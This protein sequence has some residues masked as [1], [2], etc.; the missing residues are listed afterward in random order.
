MGQPRTVSTETVNVLVIE[1]YLLLAEMLPGN[2]PDCRGVPLI[3][4]VCGSRLKPGGS[5][6]AE[7]PAP[8]FV[9][10]NW[11]VNGWKG[12]AR[13][14]LVLVIQG[15]V[16]FSTMK[17]RLEVATPLTFVA[18][19]ETSYSPMVVGTPEMRPVSESMDVPG[20]KPSAPK[21]V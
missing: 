15:N 6:T 18:K 10:C 12:I 1:P 4:P 3:R 17:V 19:R 8:L 5:P 13:T 7:K 2:K 14:K 20:G 16:P 11:K 21:P 9:S